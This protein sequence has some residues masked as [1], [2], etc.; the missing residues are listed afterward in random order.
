MRIKRPLRPLWRAI[1]PAWV[2]GVRAAER[3][4]IRLKAAPAKWLRAE[5]PRRQS[6]IA[7]Q[8]VEANAY[9]AEKPHRS[10]AIVAVNYNTAEHLAHM[11]FSLYRILGRDQFCRV[12][13]VDNASTD[14][15][16][17]LLTAL[18]GAGLVD[19]VFNQRQRYHGP[20]LNQAMNHLARLAQQAIAAGEQPVDY[21]WVLDSD[22]VVLRPDA[23]SDAVRAALVTQAGLLGQVQ[24]QEMPEGYAHVSSVLIDPVQVWRRTIAPFF[25]SGTPAEGLHTS[26]R[27]ARV[28][29]V[30]FPYRSANYVLHLGSR[31]LR[32]IRTQADAVNRYYDWAC[33]GDLFSF[34]DNPHGH[35]IY[36]RFLEAF[37]AEVPVLEPARLVAACSA[38]PRV[39]LGL[40]REQTTVSSE[41]GLPRP[42]S[43]LRNGLERSSSSRAELVSA[44]IPTY[45]YGRFVCEAVESA[46][47]QSYPAMEVI[48]VDDGSTDDTRQR[49]AAYG[50]RIRYIWQSNSGLSAA[51]NT[52]IREARGDW[53]AFLDADD[54]WHHDKTARQLA[55]AHTLGQPALIGSRGV[56]ALPDELPVEPSVRSLGVSDF[57][58]SLPVGPSGTIVRREA[59]ES[60]GLFDESLRSVEDRDMWLRL[61]ARFPAVEV[62]CPCWWY[63]THAGQ[64][65]RHAARMAANYRAVL[66]GFFEHHTQFA[67]LRAMSLSYME[68]DLAWSYYLE[69]DRGAALAGLLRS[70][71]LHPAAYLGPQGRE[72]W[73]RSKHLVRYLL[74]ART[75]RALCPRRAGCS[76]SPIN[77]HLQGASHGRA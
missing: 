39:D 5:W 54:I 42:S 69:G 43:N 51:R 33:E 10:V 25:E 58:L 32:S 56:D 72:P 34:H 26:L 47:A 44:I 63:R 53:V 66:E 36:D 75:L 71:W 73:W 28:P 30:N 7:D 68:A 40:T 13:V 62:D 65:H 6:P 37:R 21:V 8:A 48:V 4:A 19:V 45:N 52:G 20:A 27:R 55:A 59:F 64:M 31:T 70:L 60:A 46:L 18:R 38:E 24:Y 14:S 17:E 9:Q 35:V 61:A 67:P 11:L 29:I 77:T 49:L 41:D 50:S 12:V 3:S 74:G 15:S 57:L 2:S 23:V 76:Q 16:V 1:N 22:T